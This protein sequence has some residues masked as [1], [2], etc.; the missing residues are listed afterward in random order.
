MYKFQFDFTPLDLVALDGNFTSLA[1][2]VDYLQQQPTAGVVFQAPFT[3]LGGNGEPAIDIPAAG[4]GA[5]GPPG[6]QIIWDAAGNWSFTGNA[7][8]E[9]GSLAHLSDV[10]LGNLQV[11]D[12]LMWTGINWANAHVGTGGIAGSSQTMIAPFNVIT[13]GNKEPLVIDAA[14]NVTETAPLGI[15]QPNNATAPDNLN[16]WADGNGWVGLT[17]WPTG[18]AIDL[19]PNGS[20]ALGC[21]PC[22]LTWTGPPTCQWNFAGSTV[23]IPTLSVATCNVTGNASVGGTLG[24]TGSV[25][26]NG[27][28]TLPTA[29]AGT[30]STQAATTAFVQAAVAAAAPGSVPGGTSLATN[31]YT[32]LPGGVIMQWGTATAPAGEFPIDISVTFPK[33]FPHACWHVS[34]TTDRTIAQVG[35]EANLAS[36]FAGSITTS[37]CVIVVDNSTGNPSA[38]IGRWMAVGY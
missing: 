36:N 31:G 10:S 17:S 11:G 38:Y 16:F 18:N 28:L 37:G 15:I 33:P 32:T 2:A 13:S 3:V 4:G 9:I 27:G 1:S 25:S 22:Q 5:I 21:P 26:A 19:E 23:S 24:V 7:A 29:A 12:F 34:V 8:H 20:G 30:S 35:Q 6:S 14:G